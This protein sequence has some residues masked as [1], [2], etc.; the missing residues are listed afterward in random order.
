MLQQAALLAKVNGEQLGVITTQL[1]DHEVRI[2][3]TKEEL[4][5][6]K[7]EQNALWEKQKEN[8]Q[9]D[10]SQ[11]NELRICIENRVADLFRQNNFS[12]EDFKKYFGKFMNKA[13]RDV[14][15]YS[16][17]LGDA[18]V[19]TKLKYFNDV[20]EYIGTWTPHGYGVMGYKEH[21]DSLKTQ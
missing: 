21:L 7:E 1:K 20:K 14:K 5:S 17:V 18:G 11:R 10:A 3:E 8:E 19:Y 12:E 4:H 2:R 6:F 9:I 15:R 16:Y 13:W